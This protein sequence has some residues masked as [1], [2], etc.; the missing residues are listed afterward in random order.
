MSLQGQNILV[1]G[2]AVR[3]G[4]TIVEALA[5]AGARPLIHYHRSK[6]AAQ[7]LARRLY[8]KYG[9]DVPTFG[10]A[11]DTESQCQGL[12]RRASAA[13]GLS[14]LIN[15]AAVF[16]K[17]FL[18]DTSAAKLDAELRTNLMAPIRLTR[19]FTAAAAGG[20]VINLL[21]RRVACNEIGC[22]AYL[23]S[24]KALA[25]F[26]RIAALELAPR[27][28]VNAVA[29]G[30][31]LPPPGRPASALRD[32]AGRVPL[33]IQVRPEDVADAV[34]YLLR[35]A[36]VTGQIVFIDGGQHLLGGS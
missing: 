22:M 3:I 13:G 33:E 18:S 25:D 7:R 24:K 16:H 32:L 35:A 6:A 14:G 17:D 20:C 5:A 2:G 30:A 34:L 15:N 8:R 29:P 23:L 1:T 27:F 19:A 26:T 28:R 9:L 36:S 4:A 21:D 10:S 12:I 11:L 31:I